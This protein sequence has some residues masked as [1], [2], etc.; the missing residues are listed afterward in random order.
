MKNPSARRW[1][2]ISALLLL[3]MMQAATARL[4]ITEWTEFLFFTQTLAAL[5][6]ALGLA[7]GYSTFK[8]RAVILIALGYSLM[9]LPWQMT[10]AIDDELL[11]SRLASVGGRL[12]F[13]LVQFF[14]REPVEDNLLFVIL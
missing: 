8:R 12:Y 14:Q 6:L 2:W 4:V 13:A 9:L 11:S 3:L 10:L 5:G 7:L 1:N